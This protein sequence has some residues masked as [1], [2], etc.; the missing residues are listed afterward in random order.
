MSKITIFTALIVVLAIVASNKGVE[1]SRWADA[2]VVVQQK[3]DAGINKAI[4]AITALVTKTKTRVDRMGET[5]K[6]VSEEFGQKV[7]NRIERLLKKVN[8][9][10]VFFKIAIF[11]KLFNEI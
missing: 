4:N 11:N 8:N 3:V 10:F 9:I 1:A 7:Y 6:V 2:V 5:L